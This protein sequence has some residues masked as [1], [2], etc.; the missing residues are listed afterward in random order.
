MDAITAQVKD[1]YNRLADELPPASDLKDFANW[2]WFPA[3]E[4][5]TMCRATA[6]FIGVEDGDRVFEA[7]CGSGAFL[8]ALATLRNGLTLAGADIADKL[9]AIARARV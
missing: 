4:W 8:A 3:E 5:D 6:A 9:V 7:G 2:R 1:D